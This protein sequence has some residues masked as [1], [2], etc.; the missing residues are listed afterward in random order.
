MHPEYGFHA[1]MLHARP[2]RGVHVCLTRAVPELLTGVNN[3][4]VALL[5]PLAR[6]LAEVARLWTRGR[7]AL[8]T[9]K[10]PA[11]KAL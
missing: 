4:P 2:V 10:Q 11:W 6:L 3:P 5:A 1:E 8:H 7:A 9:G